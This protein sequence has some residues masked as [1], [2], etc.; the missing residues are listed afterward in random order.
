MYKRYYSRF[1]DA[2][3]GRLH[4]AAHSHH[5]WPD[6]AREA[7]LACFDDAARLAD[8]K[9][10]KIFGEVLPEARRGAARLLGLPSPDSL[11]FAP[12]THEFVVRLYSCLDFSRP[13]R[14]LTTDSEF[15]SF[16]RQTARLEEL[17][18]VSVERVPVDPIESFEDRF[19]AAAARGGHDLVFFSHVFFNSG[20]RVRSPE[21]LA[22]AVPEPEALV[23]VDGYHAFCAFPLHLSELSRRAFYLAGGYKYAQAGEGV[24]LMHCPPGAEALRPAATGWFADFESLETGIASP[25]GYG[26]DALRF[27]GSTFD[28]SGL[29]R[30]NAVVAWRDRIGLTVEKSDA[31]VRDLQ[32]RFLE[33]DIPLL[34]RSALICGDLDRI[35]HFLTYRL[36][37][38]GRI[39]EKLKEFK[40]ITDFR[41]D[42]LRFGFGLYQNR[43]DV[44][45]LVERL[46]G[47]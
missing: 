22:A 10:G 47:L 11:A 40:V 31:Y 29:Y 28:P 21:R 26:P 2:A 38:A 32:R 7:H 30:F 6:P 18:T 35:G 3:P 41:G 14:V 19:A 43:A 42:R 27:W 5:C 24:C 8:E 16:A 25:V 46:R 20:L 36:P 44:D 4:F 13:V 23:V 15:H 12:N 39:C 9:W 1:L 34:P 45:A 37:E 17:E 33:A